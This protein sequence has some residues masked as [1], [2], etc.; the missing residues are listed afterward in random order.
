MS[1]WLHRSKYGYFVSAIS[2]VHRIVFSLSI[3]ALL[4]SGWY[5]WWYLPAQRQLAQVAQT[6]CVLKQRNDFLTKIIQQKPLLEQEKNE[7]D[8]KLFKITTA[9]KIDD[10]DLVERLLEL[11]KKHALSCKTLSPLPIKQCPQCQKH[12]VRI[13]VKGQF[14]QIKSFLN[15][16]YALSPYLSCN[17]LS[18]SRLKNHKVSGDMKLSFITFGGYED[19]QKDC[20]C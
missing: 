9:A 16:L 1:F 8:Q 4:S 5:W 15:D 19:Q 10:Q 7:L 13:V 2:R 17:E 12:R 14:K 18:L 6:M 3:L 20:R 11:L